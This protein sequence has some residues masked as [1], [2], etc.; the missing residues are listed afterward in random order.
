MISTTYDY[1]STFEKPRLHIQT[2]YHATQHS[3]ASPVC[4]KPP[5]L[6]PS[7]S[8]SSPSLSP[9]DPSKPH[10]RLT[11]RILDSP[12]VTSDSWDH[13]QSPAASFLA[14]FAA[15]SPPKH[16]EDGDE[17]DEYV[18]GQIIGVGGF[19]TVRQGYRISD[20]QKVAV[21]VVKHTMANDNE[22]YDDPRL[23]RELTI[24][25]SLQHPNIVQVQKVLE[26]EQST[27]I[28][29]DYCPGNLLSKT[30]LDESDAR[31]VFV[32]LCQAVQ[33]LHNKARVCHKDLKLE[34]VL[35]DQENHV[36]L[37]DFGLAVYQQPTGSQDTDELAGGSLAYAA[38]EQVQSTHALCC[39][40]TDIWSLGIILYALV[41][42]RLPFVDDY[43]LRLQHKV[44][45]GQFDMPCVSA[46]LQHLL[47]H[48]LDTDPHTRYT[49]DDVL[50]SPWC[51]ISS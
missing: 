3:I 16:E 30:Q 5:S 43:E 6:S 19:S 44:V 38:P 12:Q 40:K 50:Q 26:T 39:P 48:C 29:C 24:W 17:I 31:T 9:V 8:T 25:K 4:V 34:N 36:K 49:I 1:I 47:S 45:S 35:L 10:H 46:E 20:G 37:C 32:E 28:V 22:D 15:T 11:R 13:I 41:T 7:S 51:A 42:G 21:K 18:L 14:A 2:N 27:Y 33:Y 23:E